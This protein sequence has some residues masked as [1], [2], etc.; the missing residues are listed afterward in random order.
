MNKSFESIDQ[1]PG[2]QEIKP[3]GFTLH[4]YGGSMKSACYQKGPLFLDI[5]LDPHDG[6]PQAKLSA[7]L[8][9]LSVI[10]LGPFSWPHKLFERFE[11]E[12]RVAHAAA[13]AAIEAFR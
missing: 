1:L 12:V 8:P 10:T 2:M 13:S 11:N 3:L 6:K 7:S 4:S 9:G 5:W